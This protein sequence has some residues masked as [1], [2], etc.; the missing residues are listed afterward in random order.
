M[1][2]GM[3]AYE[4][5]VTPFKFELLR[6]ARFE[7]GGEQSVLEIGIG[8]APN[9]QYLTRA[10]F[11]QVKFLKASLIRNVSQKACSCAFEA[12]LLPPRLIQNLLIE[13]HIV[14][15]LRGAS[16]GVRWMVCGWQEW[17]QTP[18]CLTTHE[19]VPDKQDCQMITWISS[20]LQQS[21]Y[22]HRML[23]LIPSFAHWWSPVQASVRK[24]TTRNLILAGADT[25]CCTET[26][27]CV[28]IAIW[29]RQLWVPFFQVAHNSH[30]RQR[31]SWKKSLLC[32]CFVLY[33][34]YKLLWEKCGESWSRVEGFTSLNILLLILQSPS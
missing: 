19:Q 1:A 5:A 16:C 34:V 8:A 22:L 12:P 30:R 2:T 29:G 15:P 21:T 4:E 6:D 26:S 31:S 11:Q 10:S 18:T 23:H 25:D 9:L 20:W 33:Q 32:R 17:I 3:D 7:G 24:F 13:V 27:Y 28:L 14:L